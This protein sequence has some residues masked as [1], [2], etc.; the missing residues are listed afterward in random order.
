MHNIQFEI[1]KPTDEAAFED[2]CARIYGTVFSDPLPQTNG[3][4]GQAQGG[5]D[6]FIDAPDGRIGIQCK[7][8]ANGALKFKHVVHEVSEADNANTPIIQLIVATTATSD[9]GLLRQVQDFSDNRVTAGLYPVKIEFWQDICRHI[10]GSLK[11]QND[12]A[13]NAPGAIFHRFDENNSELRASIL[14]VNA[15]LEVLVGLP[16]GRPDSVNRYL[17]SQLDAVN[18][19]LRAA[20]FEDALEDLQRIG[21]D[22]ALFDTHQQARWHVQRGICTWHLDSGAAA[23]PDFLRAAELY[24]DDEKIAASRVR[25]LLLLDRVEEA[26]A[27]GQ[28]ALARF[29]AS[30]HV[31]IAYTNAKMVKGFSVTLSDAPTAMRE[32]CDVLQLIAWARKKAGDLPGAVELSAKALAKEDATFFV[33][34]TALALALEATASDPVKF[35]YSLVSDSALSSLKQAVEAF[36]PRRERVW[37]VQSPESIQDALVHLGYSYLVLGTPEQTLTLVEEARHAGVLSPRLKRAALEAYC[38]LDRLD[39]LI[40]LGREWLNDLEEEALILVAENAS[41]VGDASLVEAVQV[42]VELKGFQQE[43]TPHLLRAIRWVALWRAGTSKK[44]ALDEVRAANITSS[45]NLVLICA[46]ARILYASKD[47]TAAEVAIAKARSLLS[48]DAPS[49]ERLLLADL[50]FATNKLELAARLYE[51]LAPRGR[52]S[53]LHNRLL[54]CYV[55][56]GARRKAKELLESFPDAWT[57]N[58]RALGLAIDLGQQASDWTFLIPLAELHCERCPQDA[59]GWLLRLALDLKMRKMARFHNTLDSA[60]TEL[61]GP[62][63]LIAQIAALELR[64][65]RKESGMK[66]LYSLFRRNLDDANAASAYFITIVAGP[67][68]LPF[69][70]DM[71]AETRPG[72][73]ITLR[74]E[75]GQTVTLSVDPDGLTDMPSRDGFVAPMSETARGLLGIAVGQPVK[76]PGHFGIE[77]HFVVEEV[78]TVFRHLLRV[79]QERVNSPVVSDLPLL[80]ISVPKTDNGADFSQMHAILKR[81]SEHSQRVFQ[82][83]GESPITLGIFGKLLGRDVVDLV[84][85]WPSDAPALFVCAGTKDQ[86]EEAVNLLHRAE[87]EYV[88]DAATV[89]E[90]A[91]LDCLDALSTLPRIYISTKSMEMLEA[92]LE[93]AKLD[94]SGGQ[95]FDDNGT[96]R[97]VEYTAQDRDRKMAFIQGTVDAVRRYCEMLPAYGAEIMPS[98]FERAHEVLEDEEHAALLLTAEK[99]ATLF[100]VDGRLAQFGLLAAGV[101][102]VWPQEVLKYAKENKKLHPQQYQLAVIRMLLRNRSFVSLQADDLVFMCLQG[103]YAL[104]EGLQRFKDYLSSSLT[105]RVSALSIAF[106]FLALQIQQVIQ[107]KAFAEIL[108]HIAEATLRHPDCERPKVLKLMHDFAHD[109]AIICSGPFLPYAHVENMRQRR[110]HT[111]AK[112]FGEAIDSAEK[113]ASMPPHRRAIKL[114]VLKCMKTPHIIFDEDAKVPIEPSRQNGESARSNDIEK[115]RMELGA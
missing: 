64:F 1:S 97:Y 98:D 50:L 103:G 25:G 73:T 19:V 37:S 17:S 39:E 13:P 51:L 72:S 92:R 109:V 83:Y 104:S 107:L 49:P 15:K 86:Q 48:N 66:R 54:H 62:P 57:T 61:S 60:P 11:L 7:K 40:R 21:M 44:Q 14:S 20:K 110:I 46:G 43:D 36:S 63:R 53:E 84:L 52:H 69:M 106:D 30:V 27:A 94:R 10:H 31:W 8:Y 9:A 100:T 102:S 56:T 111:Y 68:E 81:Q 74:N 82:V 113:L 65:E 41:D 38:R 101:K 112:A 45:D 26:L 47:E 29:P 108:G 34:N 2:M 88:I 23:A 71:L 32:N 90:L 6:V 79:A 114:Q 75:L 115:V 77:R 96:M 91:S 35:A 89:M 93:M 76:L 80:S 95:M 18:D 4:R 24:P 85:G 67:P 3:R 59:G 105:E 16:G 33:R 12:Y 99:G 58:E 78:T 70:E 42:Q 28:E 22:M 5:I 55:R 87:A